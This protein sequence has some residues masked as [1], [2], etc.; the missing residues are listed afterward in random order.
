MKNGFF[1][2]TE[3]LEGQSDCGKNGIFDLASNL[4]T[5]LSEE[6]R[7]SIERDL[8]CSIGQ[9]WPYSD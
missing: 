8:A 2:A 4:C 1:G 9:P 3:N 7:E 5:S 6:V